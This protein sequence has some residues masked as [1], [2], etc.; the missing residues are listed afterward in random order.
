[1]KNKKVMIFLAISLLVVI[2]VAAFFIFQKDRQFSLSEVEIGEVVF[3]VEVAESMA[4]RAKGLSGRESLGEDEGMLFIFNSTGKRSFWMKDMKFPIDII[5]ISED[6]IA[7]LEKNVKPEPDKNLFN[8]TNYIS[9]EG[10]DKVLE[11]NA[12]LADKFGF[13][14]G[15]EIG[16]KNNN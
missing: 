15:D 3:K 11:I 4:S 1:M 5:W 16:I 7:G 14:V 10:V 8:L 13:K 2:L 6:K 12:G 9:P